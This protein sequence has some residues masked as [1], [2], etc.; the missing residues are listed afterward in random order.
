MFN[1]AKQERKTEKE[2]FVKAFFISCK[3]HVRFHHMSW[4]LSSQEKRS[5]VVAAGLGEYGVVGLSAVV[6]TH[7]HTKRISD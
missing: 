1:L 3:D 6:S 2:P 7:V 5:Q 4:Q